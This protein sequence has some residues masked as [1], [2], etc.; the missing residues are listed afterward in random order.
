MHINYTRIELK[1]KNVKILWQY[2][3]YSQDIRFI[4][5]HSIHFDAN[6]INAL[7][8]FQSKFI[9]RVKFTYIFASI[10]NKPIKQFYLL[11]SE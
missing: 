9:S 11:R 7:I 2:S 10:R 4:S 1:R 6:R 8:S 5:F 3:A